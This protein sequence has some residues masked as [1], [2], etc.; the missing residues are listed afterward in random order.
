MTAQVQLEKRAEVRRAGENQRPISAAFCWLFEL[1]C[2][3]FLIES[4]PKAALSDEEAL[5]LA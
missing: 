4:L 3:A 5:I 2:T 1:P